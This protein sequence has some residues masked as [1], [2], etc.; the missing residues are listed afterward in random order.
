MTYKIPVLKKYVDD[1]FLVLPKDK[2]HE[3][4]QSFNLYDSHL[5]FTVEE[6]N[7]GRLPFLDMVVIRFP[8]GNMST[9][10]YSKPIASGRILNYLSLHS[11]KMK[12]NVAYN[13]VQRVNT[14][15]CDYSSEKIKALADSTT[16]LVKHCVTH[17]H[18][19]DL[20]KANV[21]DRTYQNS[22][23]N[24]LETFHIKSTKHAVNYRT[25]VEDMSPVYSEILHSMPTAPN[26][27]GLYIFS[28]RGYHRGMPEIIDPNS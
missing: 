12:I 13:F 9:E 5:Q 1:L 11:L 15:S 27:A 8:D 24:V 19:F 17:Q 28:N 16:A 20:T 22:R 23:L 10:W 7:E 6:E 3:T 14:L 21:L 25:D 4:L 26:G 18:R 2:V